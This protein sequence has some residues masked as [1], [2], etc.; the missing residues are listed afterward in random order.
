[1]KLTVLVDNAVEPGSGLPLLSEHG[2]SVL[3]ESD[4]ARILFDTGQGR[5]LARNMDF[6][7]VDPESIDALVLSHGHYDHAGGVP[8]LLEMRKSPLRVYHGPDFFDPRYAL[9]GA[10]E[11]PFIGSP[12]SVSEINERGGETVECRGGEEILPGVRTVGGLTRSASPDDRL[13]RRR[14]GALEP[15]DFRDELS[16]LVDTDEGPLLLV[17]CAHCGVPAI[18]EGAVDVTDGTS[19]VFLAGGTHLAGADRPLLRK[20]ATSLM[21]HGVRFVAANH[22]TG[23]E[24]TL[25]LAGLCPSIKTEY[26]YAGKIYEF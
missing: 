5:A 26:A 6:F 25:A 19:P 18:L 24:G 13:Q 11:P 10:G 8:I 16:L 23:V 1:V 21:D 22:C 7:G 14:D 17:G 4:R 12:L 9:V 2:L 20:T 15:D 3:M